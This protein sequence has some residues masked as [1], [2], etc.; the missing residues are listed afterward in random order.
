MKAVNASAVGAVF[1]RQ[2]YSYVGNP[3]G[4]IFIL[5]F[6]CLS[7]GILFIPDSYAI[8]GIAHFGA[9]YTVMP[10]L[11]MVFVP[12][13]AMAAWAGEREQGTEELLLT[14]PVSILDALLGKFL[15][16]VAFFT[17]ALAFNL[18]HLAFLAYLGSPDW[19]LILANLFGWWVAGVA[20]ISLGLLASALVAHQAIAF[21]LGVLL[22]AVVGFVAEWLSGGWFREFNRG[23]IGVGS[24]LSAG[25]VTFAGLFLAWLVVTARTTWHA[26][27]A[28]RATHTVINV[29]LAV[30]LCINVATLGAR[31]HLNIDATVERL[32]TLDP[33][34]RSVIAELTV[35]VTLTVVVSENLPRDLEVRSQSVV[36][37]ARAIERAAGGQVRL[38]FMH[39]ESDVD[40]EAMVAREQYGLETRQVRHETVARTE[41]VHV[42]MGAVATSGRH[43]QVIPFFDPGLPIEFE[44]VRAVRT[45]YRRAAVAL[46]DSDDPAPG[47]P[48]LGILETG[49]R[50][51]GGYDFSGGSF[52]QLPPWALV[53]EWSRQFE[54][55]NVPPHGP[56]PDDIDVL[57]AAAPSDLKPDQLGFLHDYIWSGRPCLLMID[58]LPI[59]NPA[60]APSRPRTPQQPPN[61][62]SQ[63]PP[64]EPKA[65]LQPLLRALGVDYRIDQVAWSEYPKPSQFAA[66]PRTAIW[67]RPDDGGIITEGPEADLTAALES[68]VTFFPGAFY[69]AGRDDGRLEVTPL[70]TLPRRGNFGF[71][72]IKDLL[73]EMPAFMGGGVRLRPEGRVPYVPTT[74]ARTPMIAAWIRG[75]MAY[76][77]EADAPDDDSQ[78]PQ[79]SKGDLSELPV[80]VILVSDLDMAS[81]QFH[82]VY[83]STDAQEDE[84]RTLASIGNVIF[85]SNVLDALAGDR[86]LLRVRSRRSRYR[87]HEAIEEIRRR[88]ADEMG[89]LQEQWRAE[90]QGEL[91]RARQRFE[92][93]VREIREAGGD[94]VDRT[95]QFLSAQD[96][97]Q[98]EFEA[99]TR[100]I[101]RRLELQERQKRAEFD[102]QIAGFWRRIRTL[103]IIVP[104]IL[105]LAVS[106]VVF[107]LRQMHERIDIPVARKRS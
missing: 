104:A 56:I 93:R 91:D 33:A 8:R 49:V 10:L 77:L 65:D 36:D 70:I 2:L 79:P 5:F 23:L 29:A 89:R 27:V 107:V 99:D 7:A 88:D 6:V 39:P 97:L 48:V 59:F 95:Q 31:H 85:L 32:S 12:T 26:Q 66:L 58:A 35:P 57:I 84:Q 82:A 51:A 44:L 101:E 76:A 34:S 98:R 86:E 74:T 40:D 62:F 43:R 22:C 50:M 96:T 55:R 64:P 13:L 18:S 17:L 25:A 41:V 52:N 81:D 37:M 21:V 67:N 19:G 78:D 54:I 60:L 72:R 9:L 103:S 38:R 53:D 87:T 90:V 71:V 73:E 106:A 61:Q 45:V 14:M 47:L 102:A 105:I 24:L 83:R 80:N 11:L 100:R 16:V 3:L 30:L 63:P 68:I 1:R 94:A 75:Q 42:F 92:E 20:F 28:G 15:A 4:Y 69:A 46:A